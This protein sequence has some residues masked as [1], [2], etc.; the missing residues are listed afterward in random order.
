[1]DYSIT[2]QQKRV[3]AGFHMVG[4]WEQTVKQGFEQLAMWVNGQKIPAKE[5]VAV[6]YDNPDE[7]PAEKLRCDTVVTVAEGFTPPENSEGVIVTE[8]EGGLYAK[9]AARV[10]DHDFATPWYQF[11][12]SV[13]QDKEHEL[14]GKPCFELY[15]NDG[16]QEGYWDIEM[17]VAVK[18]RH[19]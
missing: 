12:N 17:Y 7:V 1:M 6:Y 11:F 5:W 18:K 15:L 3:V 8:V 9:A 19:V 14:A 13:L 16:N 2:Q 4:P 10:L